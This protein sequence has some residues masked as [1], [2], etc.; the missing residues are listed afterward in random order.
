MNLAGAPS[1]R[2]LSRA[3]ALLLVAVAI[4]TG[5]ARDRGAKGVPPVPVVRGDSLIVFL[6]DSQSPLFLEKFRLTENRND[7]AREMIYA[8]VVDCHPNAIFHL[9]DMVSIGPYRATWRSTDAF[10]D[11]ARASGIPVFPTLGNHELMLFPSYG[12]DEFL[13]RFPWYRKTGYAVR[14]GALAVVLLNSNFGQLTG[15]E[16]AGQVSWLDSTLSVFQSDT[17][18]GAVF[19]ATHHP[20]YT[21]S[22]IVSPSK[23]VRDQLVPLYLRYSK[24]LLFLSGHCHAFEHFHQGGKDFVVIGGGGG[25]QQ[26]LLTG[27]AVRWQ[28][29]FPWKTE[30]R[31]FHYL[32]CRIDTGGVEVSVQMVQDDFSGFENAYTLRYPF[33][34]STPR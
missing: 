13:W 23:E 1:L 16:R 6:S 10:I 34:R 26:P 27:A 25:L 11:R 17:T 7:D 2:P 18:V 33:V 3:A 20:P 24:C 31:M 28:D 19:V 30:V 21:N 5:I 4:Q 8:R 32:R 22:T 12:M 14:V 9:G 15:Q 29:L